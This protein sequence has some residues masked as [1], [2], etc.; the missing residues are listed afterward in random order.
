MGDVV[1][2]VPGRCEGIGSHSGAAT[3]SDRLGTSSEEKQSPSADTSCPTPSSKSDPVLT[4]GPVRYPA[5]L[6]DPRHGE[7]SLL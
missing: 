6:G 7:S 2:F 3:G 4:S 5:N 1:L